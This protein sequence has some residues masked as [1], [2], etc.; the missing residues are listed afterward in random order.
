MNITINIPETTIIFKSFLKQFLSITLLL[1][2]FFFQM[3][4]GGATAP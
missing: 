2:I 1:F 4:V 3:F